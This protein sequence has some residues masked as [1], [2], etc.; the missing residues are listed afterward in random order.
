MNRV[1]TSS[2]AISS[3]VAKSSPFSTKNSTAHPYWQCFA[4]RGSTFECEEADPNE[5]GLTAILAIVLKKDGAIHEYLS[6]RAIPLD[7]CKEHAA[8]WVRLTSTQD[9]VCLSGEFINPS[10]DQHDKKDYTWIFESYKTAEGCDSY[11][12]GGCSLAYK[13]QHGCDLT[14]KQLGTEFVK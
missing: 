5:E 4:T 8:D 10:S 11:F 2:L 12:V 14:G 7:A 9:H 1:R 13:I 6:R 3:C